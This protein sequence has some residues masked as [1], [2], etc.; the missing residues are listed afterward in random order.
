MGVFVADGELP[1]VK[2]PLLEM[3]MANLK[4]LQ[5]RNAKGPCKL[6]DGHGLYFE[7]TVS[8]VKRWLYRYKIQGKESTFILD[9]YPDLS[10]EEAR[11]AHA[12]ARRLVKSGRN[13]ASARRER[14]VP[15]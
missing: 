6:S 15:L 14:G 8:G 3:E 12:E 10:L 13:P 4:A 5:V 2:Y 9:R 7:I 1:V 11:K